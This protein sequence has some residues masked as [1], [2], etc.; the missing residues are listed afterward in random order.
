MQMKNE[1]T[2]SRKKNNRYF[3]RT[4]VKYSLNKLFFYICK[5]QLPKSVGIFSVKRKKIAKPR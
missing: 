2:K 5:L 3:Q 4:V 1:E